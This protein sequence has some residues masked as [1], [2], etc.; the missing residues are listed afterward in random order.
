VKML[1]AAT[2]ESAIGTKPKCRSVGS[3]SASEGIVLQKSK[4]EGVQIFR[5]RTKRK[6]VTDSYDL[7]RITEVACEFIV[8]R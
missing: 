4:V 1:F 2:Q 6:S 3:M 5:K 7:N 8:R